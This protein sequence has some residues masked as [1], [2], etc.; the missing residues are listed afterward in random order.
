MQKV[1]IYSTPT[2]GYC[3]VAKDFFD[4]KGVKYEEFDVAADEAKRKELID[5]SGQIG[6]PVITIGEDIII[7][8]DQAKISELLGI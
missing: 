5:I 3:N 8:F 2:C 6:V 4:E 7:G 1:K